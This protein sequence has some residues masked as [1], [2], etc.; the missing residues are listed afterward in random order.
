[1]VLNYPFE[2]IS[3]YL[4]NSNEIKISGGEVG[5]K[6]NQIDVD[7][8][9]DFEDDTGFIY[10]TNIFEFVSGTLRQKNKRPAN[11]TFHALYN[12]NINGSCGDGVLTGTPNGGAS[13]DS[14]KLD[15][16]HDDIRYVDYDADQNANS[17][18]TGCIDLNGYEPNYNGNPSTSQVIFSISAGEGSSV[19]QITLLHYSS[20]QLHLDVLDKDGFGILSINFP[21]WSATLGTPYD[22]SLNYNFTAGETRLFIDGNQHG[23]TLTQTGTRDSNINL[24]R[25]GN[26]YNGGFTSNFK[27]DAIVIYN[28]VQHTSNYTPDWSNI[29]DYDYLGG[30]V[31]LPEME[32]VGDGYIKL[33]NSLSVTYTGLPRLLLEIERSGNKEYWDGDSWEISDESYDQSTSPVIF[34]ANC[35]LLDV[36]NKN[37]GQFTI[38]FPNSNSQSSVSELTANMNVDIYLTTNPKIKPSETIRTN[39]LQNIL[40]TINVIGSDSA[41]FTVEVDGTEKYWNGSA[42]GD[43]SGY[44]QSNTYS[45]I[46]ANSSSLLSDIS[47]IR[48]V[49]YLHSENGTTTP[50]CEL[51]TITYNFSGETPD[52]VNTCEIWWQMA[53]GNKVYIYLKNDGIKYKNNVL[54]RRSDYNFEIEAPS[55]EY[56]EVTLPDT[57]N[58]EL[59]DLGN[60]QVYIVIYDGKKYEMNVPVTDNELLFDLIGA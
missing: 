9:E 21:A 30:L 35:T 53:E 15:L 2:I 17:P 49:L 22:F 10:D 45:E 11:D 5:L 25:I 46:E 8:T 59:D 27:L 39:D 3:K 47:E 32:H 29:Y 33:F 60:E 18:Q 50:T 55:N 7:F 43:S 6:L 16:A 23:S 13:I 28:T 42:W 31:I 41:R 51:I 1:M 24:L 58:M 54:L 20:G 48:W 40:A 57:V 14:G 36:A 34:N 52:T 44:S 26:R 12:F 56:C 4:F 19:N 37:Y 38:A